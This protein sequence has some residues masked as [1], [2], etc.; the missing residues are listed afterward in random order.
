MKT[1]RLTVNGEPCGA[2]VPGRTQLAE[3][4]RDH[5]HLTGTNLGC[6]HGVCGACTVL[7]NGKPIRSCITYAHACE[8][9]NVVTVEGLGEDPTGRALREAFVR[10]HALQCGFCTPGMLIT[11]WDIVTR[12]A[13]TNEA[14]IRHELSG[15]LCR[16]TGYMGIVAAVRDVALQHR[17]AAQD[18]G[19]H[20]STADAAA[21]GDGAVAAADETANGDD[22]APAPGSPAG[23]ETVPPAPTRDDFGES[24]AAAAAAAASADIAFEPFEVDPVHLATTDTSPTGSTGTGTPRPMTQADGWITIRTRIRDGTPR[25]CTVGA[26]RRPAARRAVLAGCTRRFRRRGP[27]RGVGR[28]PFRTHRRRLPRRGEHARPMPSGAPASSPGAAPTPAAT[29]PSKPICATR[30]PA[31]SCPIRSRATRVGLAIRFRIQGALA[32]FNRGDLVESFADVMLS[33]FVRNCERRLAGEEIRSGGG[34]A[35]GFA[36]LWRMIRA[37]LGF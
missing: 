34:G 8:G 10:H 22:F 17:R 16:C 26:V 3:M 37:R 13:P 11:A 30:C 29:R 14:V 6:E 20:E 35:S 33:E 2:D 32:Q 7:V 4:L 15:N 9:A 27:L 28:D 24:A 1:I 18:G 21:A 25:R 12:L 31:M 19:A 36:L 23:G 5:L